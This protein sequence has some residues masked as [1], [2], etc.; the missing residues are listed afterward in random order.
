MHHSGHETTPS[1]MPELRFVLPPAPGLLRRCED[2]KTVRLIGRSRRP[3]S[4]KSSH[5]SHSEKWVIYGISDK[6]YAAMKF[7]LPIADRMTRSRLASLP[8]RLLAWAEARVSGSPFVCV[9]F[10]DC[11][12]ASG[13]VSLQDCVMPASHTVERPAELLAFLF[14]CRPEVKRTK[15]R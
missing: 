14:A 15:V 13:P 5:P 3:H 12:I 6:T 1:Q 9:A 2:F 10:S 11:L 7:Q 8:A 4:A